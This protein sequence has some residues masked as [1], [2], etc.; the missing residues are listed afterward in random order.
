MPLDV[1]CLVF[2]LLIETFKLIPVSHISFTAN[3]QFHLQKI[4][5]FMSYLRSDTLANIIVRIFVWFEGKKE[6]F[7]F[8]TFLR[9][10]IHLVFYRHTSLPYTTITFFTNYFNKKLKFT[11]L[12]NV[13]YVKYVWRWFCMFVCY[14]LKLGSP[15][16][17][18]TW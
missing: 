7:F 16:V 17:D 12:H 15:I 1:F 2:W 18:F 5:N 10:M 9:E 14:T 8:F 3:Y 6:T 11:S 13:Y 4:D